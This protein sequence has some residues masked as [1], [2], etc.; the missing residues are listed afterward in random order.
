MGKVAEEGRRKKLLA[1]RASAKS[2]RNRRLDEAR[3]VRDDLTRLEN[4]NTALREAN[5]DLQR[6]ITEAYAAIERFHVSAAKGNATCD[7]VNTNA[8]F[9]GELGM[10]P[11]KVHL[12]PPCWTLLTRAPPELA[13]SS[14]LPL[15]TPHIVLSRCGD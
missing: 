8:S 6:R 11:P 3:A 14:I 15:P 4:E 12:L 10:Q 7:A 5:V 1:N 9:T 2:S 13:L